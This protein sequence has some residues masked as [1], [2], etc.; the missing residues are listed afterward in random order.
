MASYGEA[1][2]IG[3]TRGRPIENNAPQSSHK[4]HQLSDGPYDEN[5][6]IPPNSPICARVNCYS[7]FRRTHGHTQH[8]QSLMR[9]LGCSTCHVGEHWCV[10]GRTP[11]IPI[12]KLVRY[13][14]MARIFWER[15]LTFGSE[16]PTPKDSL[17]RSSER[18]VFYTL[19]SRGLEEHVQVSLICV[20]IVSTLIHVLYFEEFLI[21]DSR[22]FMILKNYWPNLFGLCHFPLN[23]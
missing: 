22:G 5:R 11:G 2:M 13:K 7:V 9:S 14:S 4:Y 18:Y 17:Y 19:A 23:T 12:A 15:N 6:L 3:M 21:H 8:A 16:K 1:K 20:I 10:V